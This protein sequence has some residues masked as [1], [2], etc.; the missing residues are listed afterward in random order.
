MAVIPADSKCAQTVGCAALSHGQMPRWARL[1]ITDKAP[2]RGGAICP[3]PYFQGKFQSADWPHGFS[4]QFDFLDSE[5]GETNR[6]PALLKLARRA[7][8]RSAI[9]GIGERSTV[10][11]VMS[12]SKSRFQALR[13]GA[14]SGSDSDHRLQIIHF[15]KRWMKAES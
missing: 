6:P 1:L 13:K 8:N 15:A 14:L 11:A 3:G 12:L 10:L 5:L 7:P 2:P 4:L 9:R